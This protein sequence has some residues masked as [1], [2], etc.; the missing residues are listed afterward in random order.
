MFQH[1]YIIKCR[2]NLDNFYPENFFVKLT[3]IITIGIYRPMNIGTGTV[4]L[5]NSLTIISCS[6]FVMIR[7]TLSKDD[8]ASSKANINCCV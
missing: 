2:G 5:N 8:M 7:F 3:R 6:S 1:Y 4:E